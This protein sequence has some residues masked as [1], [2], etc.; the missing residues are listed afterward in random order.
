MLF[1]HFARQRPFFRS[2][3]SRA[4]MPQSEKGL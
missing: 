3:F 2:L 1:G 4:Q